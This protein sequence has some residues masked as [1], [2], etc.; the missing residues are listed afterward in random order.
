MR[1]R[2][3][4]AV[5][6]SAAA[7]TML[8]LASGG[9]AMSA[10]T[11][12]VGNGTQLDSALGLVSPGDTIVLK[13]G[14]YFTVDASTPANGFE[15]AVDNVT[16]RGQTTSGGKCQK[17]AT[18]IVDGDNPPAT[19]PGHVG[20]VFTV[21]A[22]NIQFNCFTMRYGTAGIVSV[23]N[24]GLNVSNSN[25][26][27]NGRDLNAGAPNGDAIWV[28]DGNNVKVNDSTFSGMGFDGIESDVSAN[29]SNDAW[30]V[31]KNTF[32][33]IHNSCIDMTWTTNSVVGELVSGKPRNGN[34]CTVS[35]T[36]GV[37]DAIVVDDKGV[38]GPNQIYANTVTN[39][40]LR[41]F[42]VGGNFAKFFGNT[43]VT[44]H[45]GEGARLNGDNITSDLFTTTISSGGTSGD[46]V[47]ATGDNLKLT[48][49]K[50][51]ATRALGI[52]VHGKNAVVKNA[53]VRQTRFTCF[54]SD[55]DKQAWTDISCGDV[56]GVGF[57]GL[58]ADGDGSR[59]TNVSVGDTDGSCFQA[60]GPNEV[61]TT[62]KCHGSSSGDGILVN[63]HDVTVDGFDFKSTYLDCA[64]ALVG[65]V[66]T[67]FKNGHCGRVLHAPAVVGF[68]DGLLIN[69]VVVDAAW[70]DCFD[71][72]AF[73]SADGTLTNSVGASCGTG[74]FGDGI[75]WLGTGTNVI[76][77]NDIRQTSLFSLRTVALGGDYTITNNK[78]HDAQATSCVLVESP[79]TLT[80]TGNKAQG[81]HDSAYELAA[82]FDPIVNN[83]NG[84]DASGISGSSPTM[85]VSCLITCGGGQVKSNVLDGGGNQQPGLLVTNLAGCPGLTISGNTITNMQGT[86]L[87]VDGL[88]C[89]TLANNTVQDA[90]DVDNLFG[91]FLNSNA[92]TL[93]GSDVSF[94]YDNG[95]E[96]GGDSNV[97]TNNNS[98]DN[99]E[100]GIHV[101][102]TNASLTG[103]TTKNNAGEGLENDGAGTFLK[104]NTSS[105]N[106]Q[107]CAGT[108]L[109]LIDG[110]G[111]VCADG[112]FFTDPGVITAPVRRH[113]LTH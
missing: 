13:S 19:G 70:G 60:N 53:Q 88:G 29:P 51:G 105:G 7:A 54:L 8:M 81:C 28:R 90:S 67:T 3:W 40:W 33:N 2:L 96:V 21:E 68:A 36:N 46:C 16:I 45:A 4:Q 64:L 23:G 93:T 59:L 79:N 98:H 74:S 69:K 48:N 101:S 104:K 39:A 35:G 47:D 106:R 56:T 80:L 108:G 92:N 38:G 41:C 30:K 94:G 91:I 9:S 87:E 71:F 73:P 83:N 27:G 89:N 85:H 49:T 10:A 42:F 43:C 12:T 5:T 61:W 32:T 52:E 78:F 110:G 99:G 25:F 77:G 44:S 17:T 6:F 82:R 86:G 34:T 37:T 75:R 84:T 1:T 111:N 97:V 24:D 18:T 76:S 26:V 109:G 62:I 113:H 112:T 66:N 107:D 15:I 14:T 63:G 58:S 55:G 50:C 95:I 57:L 11:F 22:D 31:K 20:P 72:F 65:T 103:N 102:G 100:D